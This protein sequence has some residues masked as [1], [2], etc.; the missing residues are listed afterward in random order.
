MCLQE[1]LT[2]GW[3]AGNSHKNKVQGP[4]HMQGTHVM[5]ADGCK[6]ER[7][8]IQKELSCIF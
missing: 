7:F 8:S 3:L 4:P 1:G 2:A 5:D 6:A